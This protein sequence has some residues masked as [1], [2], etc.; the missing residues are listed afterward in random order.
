[1]QQSHLDVLIKHCSSLLIINKK[2]DQKERKL[3]Y[4]QWPLQLLGSQFHLSSAYTLL[5]QTKVNCVRFASMIT[6]LYPVADLT[7]NLAVG[8][9]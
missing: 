1:M 9:G 3:S 2:K 7:I 5:G 8:M 6:K 4:F